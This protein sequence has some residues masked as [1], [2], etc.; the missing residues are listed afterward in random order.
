[1]YRRDGN[2][3]A[4]RFLAT[5][6]VGVAL[7]PLGAGAASAM[8]PDNDDPGAPVVMNLGDR[9]EQDTTEATTSTGD[10]ALN[11]NCGAPATKAAV[12]Y[13]YSPGASRKVLM[14]TSDSDYSAGVMVFEGTPTADSLLTCGPGAAGWSARAGTTY[15]VMAFSDTDVNGG[16]LV[17]TLR[18]VPTPHAH[19]TLATRG[20]AFHGGAARLHGTYSCNHEASPS[21]VDPHLVQRAGRLKIQADSSTG[22]RCDGTRHHWSV[23]LVSPVGTY[24]RGPAVA[25]VDIV[26]CGLLECHLDKAKRH[27]HLAWAPRSHGQRTVHRATPPADRPQPILSRHR[28]WP[29]S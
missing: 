8:P 27:V 14:D 6:V 17:L 4:L 23:R 29:S 7:V 21:I 26:V 28:H 19:V 2:M 10:D 24:A 3:K 12:W 15:Y 13:T 1:V 5:A 16:H 22:I 20:V 11:V 18:G 25:R 9:V